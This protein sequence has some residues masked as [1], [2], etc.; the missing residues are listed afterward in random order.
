[1]PA[2]PAVP[3]PATP[4]P[5]AIDKLKFFGKRYWMQLLAAA[6]VLTVIYCKRT[7]CRNPVCNKLPSFL[8]VCEQRPLP[9]GVMAG[10]SAVL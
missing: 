2:A 5:S 7:A 10:P 1:M 9:N 6:F 3:V 8:K 4:K